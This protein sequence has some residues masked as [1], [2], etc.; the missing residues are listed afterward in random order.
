MFNMNSAYLILNYLSNIVFAMVFD[1]KTLITIL[2][3]CNCYYLFSND[4]VFY[5]NGIT[6][7]FSNTKIEERRYHLVENMV[8][9]Q[10]EYDYNLTDYFSVGGYG[11]FGMFEEWIIVID[12]N[13]MGRSFERYTHSLHY[14]LNS[15]LHILPF[16]LEKNIPRFDL[17]ISGNLGL[18]SLFSS[19]D[20]NITPERGHYFDYSLMGGSSIYFSKKFG[21]FIEAGYRNFKYHTGFNARYGL[22]IRF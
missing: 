1:R 7:S 10:L 21:L 15:K 5:N 3:F 12:S 6:F 4:T 16:I 17:F 20:E 14:G 11:G 19:P 18:I 13:S 2:L 8:D 22:I 9:L